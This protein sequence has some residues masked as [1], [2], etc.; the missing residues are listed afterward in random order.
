MKLK[1]GEQLYSLRHQCE[2]LEDLSATLKELR[3]I[4][5]RYVQLTSIC[6][7]ES[8]ELKAVLEGSDILAPVCHANVPNLLEDPK[9]EIA[10][11]DAVGCHEIGIGA[12]PKDLRVSTEG[13]KSFLKALEPTLEIMKD[14]GQRLHYHNHAHDFSRLE[15]GSRV[16]DYI[17]DDDR[18]SVL[19]D[20]YWLHMAGYNE[21]DLL[22]SLKGKCTVVHFKDWELDKNTPRYAPIGRGNLDWDGIY[23]VCNEIGVEYAFVEQ[24]KTFDDEPEMDCARLSYEFMHKKGWM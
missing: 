2:T 22:R 23:N 9:T 4:G 16:I 11:Y 6:P 12:V 8:S 17:L 18:F 13:I 20:V 3:R 10:F 21:V 19:A 24:D 14:R 5:Y 15:D 1:I 7:C